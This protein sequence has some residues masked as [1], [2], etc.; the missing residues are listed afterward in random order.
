MIDCVKRSREAP[1]Y[2]SGFVLRGCED[3]DG[4]VLRG[5]RGAKIH[6][7]GDG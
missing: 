5:R 3:S 4:D 6:L 7:R 2:C 1:V